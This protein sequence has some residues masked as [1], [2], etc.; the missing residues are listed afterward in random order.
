M[1]IR[2][3]VVDDSIMFRSIIRKG[4]ANADDIEVVDEAQ[5]AFEA[6]DMI[7]Q[8]KPDVLIMDINMP[9]MSGTDFLAQLMEQTPLPCILITAGNV[10]EKD[11][12][13]V[14]AAGFMKKPA[15]PQETKL[16]MDGLAQKVRYASK[17]HPMKR[18]PKVQKSAVDGLFG[19]NSRST[20]YGKVNP[21]MPSLTDVGGLQKR[22]DEGYIIALGA[23]T[24]GTEA[25]ECVLTALPKNTPPVI[26]VQHMPPVFTKMYAERLDRSCQMEVKEGENGDKLKQGRII[27]APGGLQFGI[28]KDPLGSGF[29]AEIKE[30]EK[31]SGHCPSVDNM[32]NIVAAVAGRKVIAAL[33]T[34][35][36]ADGAKGLLKLRQAGAYTIGQDEASSV[37][38]GMPME[39]YKLGAC[40]EQQ[41]LDN[42]GL[43]ICKTLSAGWR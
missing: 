6:G 21:I 11:A 37:V 20:K 41:P 40:R 18:S 19:S 27:I 2:C 23:S 8:S 13:S 29:I 31:V 4:L 14:G 24:G 32:F 22:A 36:G 3:L 39:A 28:K 43:T 16:F 34:G 9:K 15:S 7:R 1:A 25:L 17:T 26:V 42:I 12:L 35:M 38:Y 30:G 5:D 33:L 10:T